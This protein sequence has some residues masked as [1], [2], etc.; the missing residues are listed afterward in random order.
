MPRKGENI[1]KR[2]D[3]RW[4]GRYIK[5][6]DLSGKAQY[7]SVYAKT[8]L[9][10]KHKLINV[11]EKVLNN[12]FV[13]K[14]QKIRYREI[15]YLWLES[16]RLKLKPQTYAKYLYI[17]ERHILP[18]IDMVLLNKVDSLFINRLLHAKSERGKL[19]GTGGLSPN[20]IRT[21][22]F[23]LVAS[24]KYAAR[25]GYN[26]ASL[27][28]I[29]KPVLRK[30]D[31][32]IL[33]VQEQSQLEQ[34]IVQDLDERKLGVLLSLYTGMRI[35]EVCGL[36][37]SDID[38]EK[39]IIHIHHS[40]ERIHNITTKAG[41]PKT[42]LVLC[43]VKTLSSNRIIPIPTN[44]YE[45][46]RRKQQSSDTFVIRGKLYDFTDPRTFQ[47]NFHRYLRACGIRNVNY[48][49]VRHTFA[50]RCVE[51]GMDIKTLSE[52]LGHASVNITL[53][54]Y[55]HSSLERKRAQLEAM[56]IYC[57]QK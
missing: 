18:S 28:E 27:G 17:I 5:G 20:Y 19:D 9:E 33:T 57:G 56:T 36:R 14:D 3:G 25:E 43:D 1:H 42:R 23:I 50:T 51:A 26:C 15:I 24:I 13:S 37:W 44:L 21:I 31:L 35:G 54:T 6:Y 2:K 22:R 7:G 52:I 34:Y 46:L 38:F 12:L 41:D 45:L 53:N 40:I 4:E 32:E 8:Y 11:S 29:S 10:T 48:H 16:N 55:V 47:Y 30:K 49:A 39:R